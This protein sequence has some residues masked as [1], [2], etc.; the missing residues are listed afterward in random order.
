MSNSEP[1]NEFSLQNIPTYKAGIIQSA[2][3]RSLKRFT[4]KLL[5]P[6]GLTTMHW[7]IAGAVHDSGK[8]GITVTDLAKQLGTGV[9]FLTNMVN[10]LESKN[11][12]KRTSNPDDVRVK[13]IKLTDS[14]DTK[15]EEIEESLRSAMRETLYEHID[16]EDFRAYIKVLHQLAEI[17]DY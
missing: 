13:M 3:Q 5:K 2:S 14:F 8:T 1:T 4:D 10:L 15:F 9:P 6:H 12:L 7:F 16:P 11:F 17:T